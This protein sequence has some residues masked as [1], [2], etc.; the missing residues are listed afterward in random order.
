[1]LVIFRIFA[2]IFALQQFFCIK[3][4]I[5]LGN[6]EIIKEV[7]VTLSEVNLILDL[8]LK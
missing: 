4:N 7:T 5:G 3:P 6:Y 1:M 8:Y 2:T